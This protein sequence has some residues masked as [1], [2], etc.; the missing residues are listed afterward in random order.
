M[1]FVDDAPSPDVGEERRIAMEV[2]F[3]ES[4]TSD[5]EE[6]ETA[7]ERDD[8]SDIDGDPTG[9]VGVGVDNSEGGGNGI[10][11]IGICWNIIGSSISI[12]IDISYIGLVL[13][14]TLSF[15]IGSGSISICITWVHDGGVVS[16]Q[17][18]W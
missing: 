7:M 18:L 2:L 15:H 16:Y 1:A 12:G 4:L 8:G 11:C 5:R 3:G 13:W 6:M 9:D 14:R 10:F 17:L